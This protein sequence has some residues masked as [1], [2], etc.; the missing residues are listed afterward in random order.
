VVAFGAGSIAARISCWR[1]P[2]NL[3]MPAASIGHTPALRR[4]PIISREVLLRALQLQRWAVI[5]HSVP[6]MPPGLQLVRRLL[7]R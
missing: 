7:T 5:T 3:G 1:T 6:I 2:P 4:A